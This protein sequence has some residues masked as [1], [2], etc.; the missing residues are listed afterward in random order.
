[1]AQILAIEKE[2]H[3]GMVFIGVLVRSFFFKKK[4]KKKKKLNLKKFK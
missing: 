2:C 3:P 4:K 1:V